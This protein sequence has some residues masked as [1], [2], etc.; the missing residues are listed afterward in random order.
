MSQSSPCGLPVPI[1]NPPDFGAATRLPLTCGSSSAASAFPIDPSTRFPR[2]L[3]AN[4]GSKQSTSLACEPAAACDNGCLSGGRY[5]VGHVFPEYTNEALN[6]AAREVAL[7]MSKVTYPIPGIWMGP[8]YIHLPSGNLVFQVSTL[9]SGPLDAT[10]V[11]TYNSLAACSESGFGYGVSS[12]FNPTVEKMSGS[13]ANLITGTGK[14]LVYT[15]V[16]DNSWS[17]APDATRNALKRNSDKTWIEQQPDGLEWHY[18]VD[19]SLNKI[20]SPAGE[21][22]TMVYDDEL[23]SGIV[24]PTGR[25]TTI[26]YS[27]GNLSSVTDPAGRETSIEINGSTQL[28]KVTY[29]DGSVVGLAYDDDNLLTSFTDP[30]NNSTQYTY[31]CLHRV[32]SLTTPEGNRYTYT[33]SDETSPG[34]Q[35]VKVT[36]PANNITTVIHDGDLVNSVIDPLGHRTTYTWDGTQD[37]RVSTITDPNG[38]TTTLGYTTKANGTKALTSIAK[39][40]V[41]TFYFNYNGSGQCYTVQD[42]DGNSTSLDWDGNQNRVSIVDAESRRSTAIYNSHRQI[43]A[44]IDSFQNRTT[45]TYDSVGNATALSNELNFTTNLTYNSA[46]DATQVENPLSQITGYTRNDLGRISRVREDGSRNRQERL[47][48]NVNR[49]KK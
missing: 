12:L 39:P 34:S 20:V 33:Y 8:A 17:T 45:T 42:Y 44:T 31:D 46:G 30:D 5:Q 41:G 22:W 47:L 2:V 15:N 49:N 26:S 37:A 40:G 6:L 43:S 35:W 23:V 9:E 3:T 11:F 28:S 38:N 27:G 1:I 25:R 24:S 7:A 16:V 4:A 19:G 14:Y 10:P 18:K 32:E 48:D 36:D 21:I 13:E 29:P